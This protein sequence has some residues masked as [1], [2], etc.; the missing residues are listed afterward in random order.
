[1]PRREVKISK[2][3]VDVKTSTKK[4]EGFLKKTDFKED[5]KHETYNKESSNFA[6][7]G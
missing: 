1:M 2:S 7:K 3:Y 6:V 5:K 4:Q